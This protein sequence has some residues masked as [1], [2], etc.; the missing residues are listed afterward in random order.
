MSSRPVIPPDA[1]TFESV[2]GTI[3]V[4]RDGDKV[5]LTGTYDNGR[6]STTWVMNRDAASAIGSAL[7]RRAITHEDI[8]EFERKHGKEPTR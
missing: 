1:T 7:L 5:V 4:Y 6:G 3:S 2:E 8:L